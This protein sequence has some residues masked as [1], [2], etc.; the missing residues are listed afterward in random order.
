M[1]GRKVAPDKRG[2]L[3]GRGG[4]YSAMRKNF[5]TREKH[6]EIG[7]TMVDS[8]KRLEC[9]GGGYCQTSGE[10]KKVKVKVS[11]RARKEGGVRSGIAEGA[12]SFKTKEGV[13][14]SHG[15]GGVYHRKI[16]KG[17]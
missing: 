10:A 5:F 17:E 7:S 6:D 2:S 3:E 8:G 14:N 1:L 11:N 4:D 16:G 13:F 9:G 12:K 15:R